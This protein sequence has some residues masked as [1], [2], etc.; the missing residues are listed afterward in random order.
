MTEVAR[1]CKPFE[2]YNEEMKKLRHQHRNALDWAYDIGV[3]VKGFDGV[4]E[5]LTGLLLWVA[6][7]L[8]HGVLQ[9]LLG[10]AQER[11][12]QLARFAA[13]NIARIDADL[14]RSGLVVV[15]V[16][17]IAHGVVKIALVIALFKQWRWAYP[18]AI[19]VLGMFLLYQVYV[20][21]KHP[22]P[23]M[24]LFSLL[25]ALIVWLVYKEYRTLS[26][27]SRQKMVK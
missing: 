1:L 27:E 6:P 24:A 14:T 4:M 7:G 9:L 17:L 16:F 18:W 2:G 15:I 11:H 21:V 22:A 19:A 8:L 10:E 3:T 26:R 23:I 25:D 13:E 20:F 12:T 5:L